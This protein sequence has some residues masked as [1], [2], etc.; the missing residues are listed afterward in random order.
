VRVSFEVMP[1]SVV[2]E[3]AVLLLPGDLRHVDIAS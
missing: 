3:A 1:V 2:A